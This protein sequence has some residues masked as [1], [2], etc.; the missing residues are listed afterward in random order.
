[1]DDIH[2]IMAKHNDITRTVK[3]TLTQDLHETADK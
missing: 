3:G 1:M 2:Q